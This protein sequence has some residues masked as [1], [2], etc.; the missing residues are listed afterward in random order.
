[1]RQTHHARRNF[2]WGV[3]LTKT[4]ERMSVHRS[5]NCSSYTDT[6]SLL[7][8][9]TARVPG[10]ESCT[11]DLPAAFS[12]QKKNFET[13]DAETTE[14]LRQKAVEGLEAK[15]CD[16]TNMELDLTTNLVGAQSLDYSAKKLKEL[17]MASNCFRDGNDPN[18]ATHKG[19]AKCFPMYEMSDANGNRIKNT[20]KAFFSNLSVCDMSDEAMPQVEE[21]LRKV[22]AANAEEN[23]YTVDAPEHLA[24]TF[25]ILPQL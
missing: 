5:S 10:D 19:E 21:D 12:C 22:A 13:P 9:G 23:G 8:T 7:V 25:S 20:N 14:F 15:Y 11:V 17:G 6:V 2:F 24:C 1:M 3:V 16:A 4:K 18:A